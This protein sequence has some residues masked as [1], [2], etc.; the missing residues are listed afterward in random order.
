VRVALLGVGDI[1]VAVRPRAGAVPAGGARGGG[2]SRRRARPGR[3]ARSG[4]VRGLAPDELLAA[5]DVEL[6]VN[7][8]PPLAHVETTRAALEAV[9]ARVLREAAR[10]VGGGRSCVAGARACSAGSGSAARRTPSSGRRSRPRS[11]RCPGLGRRSPRTHSSATGGRSTG[12]P[13]P[14]R[15]TSRRGPALQPRP[16]LRHCARPAPR[17]DRG[18]RRVPL[19]TG[20]SRGSSARRSRRRTPGRSASRTARSRRSSR[21]TTSRGDVS[22]RSRCT[23]ARPPCPFRTRTSSTPC[24]PRTG[25]H[26]GGVAG[27]PRDGSR[28]W[29]RRRRPRRRACRRTRAARKRRAGAARPRR[30]LRVCRKV[31]RTLS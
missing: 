13:P 24:P 23:G 9:Q 25:R 8:T 7:L 15:T 3:A 22:P 31:G 4:A 18:G 10:G 14:L 26:V 1:A 5:D 28:A 29:H 12:T 20:T 11:R 2:R 6:V 17:P 30:A 21:A 19:A 27:P 16:V